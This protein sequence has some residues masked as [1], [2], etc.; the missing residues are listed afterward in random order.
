M[1]RLNVLLRDSYYLEFYEWP[2]LIDNNI[3]F[4]KALNL[5]FLI[6]TNREKFINLYVDNLIAT[7]LCKT[8]DSTHE[9]T[10]YFNI[11]TNIS[12]LFSKYLQTSLLNNLY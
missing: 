9:S 6:P 2:E 1:N 7:Y 12:D 11:I 5:L 10:S 3:P 4:T 8:I